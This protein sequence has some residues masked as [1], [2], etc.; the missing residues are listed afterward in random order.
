M[1]DKRLEITLLFPFLV[2]HLFIV[3]KKPIDA[4]VS[5]SFSLMVRME[6]STGGFAEVADQVF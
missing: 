6:C 3:L 2:F 5:P 1:K 4:F